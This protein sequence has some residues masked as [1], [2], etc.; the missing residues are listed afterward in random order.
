MR[1]KVLFALCCIAAPALARADAGMQVFLEETLAAVREKD[2]LPA[3]A[4]LVQVD[5]RIEAEA[6][7]GVRALGHPEKVTLGDR[8]HIGS[9]TKAF[10]ST[11]I[12]RLVERHVM[13]FD[14][15]LGASFPS[16]AQDMDPAYRNVTVMQLLSHTA[17]LPALTDD[18]DLPEFLAVI[19]TAKGVSAQR[20][21][22]ARYYLTK[23][24][25]SKSGDFAYS[26]VG[27]I[28]AGAIAEAHTGKTWEQLI[29][30]LVFEPLGITAAGFGAPGSAG[31][32]D[33][34]WG[35][36]E[37]DGKLVPLDPGSAEADNPPA[38]G[39]AG[40]I[41]IALQDWVLFAQ[42]QLNGAH[43]HGK[44]LKPETYRTLQ[45]PVTGNYAL[46]W[47]AKLGPDG[48]PLL[49][50]HTGSNGFWVADVRIMPLH[51][52]IFLVVTNAGNEAANEAVQD[53][54]KPLKD[55]LKPFE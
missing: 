13:S 17:G 33:E 14:D 4:A 42:D 55:R 6:A 45:T 20:V 1:P 12:A 10:T 5:G 43:G 7:L 23:S 52:M 35:H 3:V 16:F 24:P 29:R 53:I 15:T 27:F 41:N 11:M 50:T 31:K 9:D 46:G 19:Q 2:Q 36:D 39:P 44:L 32:F 49:L 51:N 47:G 48:V 38:L 25:A 37:V 22:I 40:T 21:A 26:N 28:I 18:K 34:P 8:W 54:G 30:E